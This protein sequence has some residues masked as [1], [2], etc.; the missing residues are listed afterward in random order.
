M[1]TAIMV[2]WAQMTTAGDTGGDVTDWCG[3]VYS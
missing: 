2:V 3:M 1:P